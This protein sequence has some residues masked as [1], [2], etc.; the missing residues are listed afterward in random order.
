MK[1]EYWIKKDEK[2]MQVEHEEYSV[3]VG[4]KEIR[5]ST[6]RLSIIHSM[7]IPYRYM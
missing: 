5:P 3:F 4:E 6:W 2:W 7:L 1:V